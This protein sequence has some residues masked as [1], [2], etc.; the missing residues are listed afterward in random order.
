MNVAGAELM[1]NAPP[2][3]LDRKL[4][5][6]WANPEE[7]QAHLRGGDV[8]VTTAGKCGVDEHGRNIDG[9]CVEGHGGEKLRKLVDGGGVVP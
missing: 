4:K 7:A 5:V 1:K 2:G 9:R 6:R 8:V 3:V